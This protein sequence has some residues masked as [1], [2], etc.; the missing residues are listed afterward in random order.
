MQA[1][2]VRHPADDK[3]GSTRNIAGFFVLVLSRG[4]EMFFHIAVV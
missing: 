2:T 1:K 3:A 4:E